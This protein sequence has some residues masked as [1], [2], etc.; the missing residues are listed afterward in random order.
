MTLARAT[1]FLAHEGDV[2][3]A[4]GEIAFDPAGALGDSLEVAGRLFVVEDGSVV[5]IGRETMESGVEGEFI[6][7]G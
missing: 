1:E 5:V 6:I 7:F 4:G 2:F 3:L